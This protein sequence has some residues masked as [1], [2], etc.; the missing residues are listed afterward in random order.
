MNNLPSTPA[1]FLAALL[2]G[3]TLYGLVSTWL[4]D[5]LIRAWERRAQGRISETKRRWVSIGVAIAVPVLA[6]GGL[7]ALGNAVWSVDGLYAAAMAGVAAVGGSKISYAGRESLS[8]PGEDAAYRARNDASGDPD[9]PNGGHVAPQP[10]RLASVQWFPVT[11]EQ[12]AE[13]DRQRAA[14]PTAQEVAL[15]AV[16]APDHAPD[17]AAGRLRSGTSWRRIWG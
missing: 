9:A 14:L 1:D 17:P 13:Y 4:I 7:C 3:G 5:L 12:Q 8:K 6:Y 2:A 10:E 11:P 15:R 16:P